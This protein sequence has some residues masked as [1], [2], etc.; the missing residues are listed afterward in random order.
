MHSLLGSI[1]I[2]R[3]ALTISVKEHLS[4]VSIDGVKYPQMMWFCIACG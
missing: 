4:L 2:W 1:L 3:N